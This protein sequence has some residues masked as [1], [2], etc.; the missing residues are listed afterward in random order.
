MQAGNAHP[1]NI[2]TCGAV[3]RGQIILTLG[4]AG[5][6]RPSS[7]EQPMSSYSDPT[8]PLTAQAAAYAD[9]LS[10]AF[11][12]HATHQRVQLLESAAATSAVGTAV[13]EGQVADLAAGHVAYNTIAIA[14]NPT[15]ADTITIKG[16]VYEFVTAGG[17]VA[18]DTNI[19]V[20]RGADVGA[21]MTNLL[22][23]INAT[24]SGATATG[25]LQTDGE[26]A[27]LKNGTENVT[28][29]YTSGVLRIYA[30]GEPGGEVVAGTT[31][32]IAC[33]DALTESTAWAFANLNLSTGGAAQPSQVA[34]I[35]FALTGPQVSAGSVEI[36]VPVYST[37]MKVWMNATTA[38]G[39]FKALGADTVAV[40]GVAGSTSLST[41]TLTLNGSGGDLAATNIVFIEVWA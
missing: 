27:A 15:A 38:A 24:Y 9:T 31:P 16:D 29:V 12:L 13:V 21:S 6:R 23:A 33:S 4:G 1:V 18:A 26:T 32:D 30:A 41:V 25:L 7:K 39:A 34:R 19:G 8:T 5:P 37:T 3:M 40:A 14:V 10:P 20:V 17:D 22:A 11:S 35:S 28:A 2:S 36:V